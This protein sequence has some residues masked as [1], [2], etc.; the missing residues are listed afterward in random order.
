ME[1]AVTY[2]VYILFGSPAAL[3]SPSKDPEHLTARQHMP[4][5]SISSGLFHLDY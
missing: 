3:P 5:L 4:A 1:A 2:T